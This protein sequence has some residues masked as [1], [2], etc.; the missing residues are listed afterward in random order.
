MQRIND[1][2]NFINIRQKYSE[3]YVEK[4]KFETSICILL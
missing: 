3:G 1:I 2:Y 4:N